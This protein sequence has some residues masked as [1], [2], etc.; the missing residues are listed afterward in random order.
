M[1]QNVVVVAIV[2]LLLLLLTLVLMLVLTLLDVVVVVIVVVVV[3]AAAVKETCFVRQDSASCVLFHL[4]FSE[5]LLPG[6][7][8]Q[9]WRNKCLALYN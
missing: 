9:H 5:F 6:R 4:P 1:L 7:V 3:V 8:V 2:L